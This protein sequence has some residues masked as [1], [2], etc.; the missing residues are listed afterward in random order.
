MQAG[1]TIFGGGLLLAERAAKEKD[2]GMRAA[3]QK[4]AEEK[5]DETQT[6]VWP[7]SDRERR[8]IKRLGNGQPAN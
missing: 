2:G 4:A 1:K 8:I 7:L 5:T 6:T 3:T